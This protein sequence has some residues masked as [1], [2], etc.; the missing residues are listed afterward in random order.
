[1]NFFERQKSTRGGMGHIIGGD[2]PVRQSNV[3]R[4]M[5]ICGALNAE[6]LQ[7]LLLTTTK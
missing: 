7:A 1:M 6:D 2:C 4:K 3:L 5:S